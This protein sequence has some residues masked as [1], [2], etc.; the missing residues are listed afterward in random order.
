MEIEFRGGDYTHIGYLLKQKVC[1]KGLWETKLGEKKQRNHINKRNSET[2][3]MD[4]NAAE[5]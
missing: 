3:G 5:S 1:K 2:S 4:I